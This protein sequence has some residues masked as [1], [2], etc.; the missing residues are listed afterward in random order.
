MSL[1]LSP[2][3]FITLAAAAAAAAVLVILLLVWALIL[4]RRRA[5]RARRRRAARVASSRTTAA[6]PSASGSALPAA[7]EAASAPAASR[8]DESELAAELRRRLA[9]SPLDTVTDAGSLEAPLDRVIWVENGHELLVHLGSLVA[10][11]RPGLV[12]VSLDVEADQAGRTTVVVPFAVSEG[13]EGD[14]GSLV[15][16]TEERPRGDPAV[17]AHWG[18]T[19]QEALW[20]ALLG[21]VSGAAAQLGHLPTAI[22]AADGVLHRH[23]A[24]VR[25]SA[26]AGVLA[27]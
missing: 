17:V 7:P 11:V 5:H 27:S 20:A 2:P 6:V 22:T 23:S 3:T 15:A 18:T 9:G 16:V 12:L 1:P 14:E 4:L 21:V 13:T 8:M 19:I 26:S 25:V 10:R 24:P